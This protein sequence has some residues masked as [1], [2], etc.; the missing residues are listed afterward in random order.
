MIGKTNVDILPLKTRLN[1]YMPLALSYLI[2]SD[3]R[4]SFD[5][6]WMVYNDL[7]ENYIRK[8][9]FEQFIDTLTGLIYAGGAISRT[10]VIKDAI[11][12][13]KNIPEVNPYIGFRKS[14][15]LAF[16]PLFSRALSGDYYNGITA[17]EIIESFLSEHSER[18]SAVQ[19]IYA[20]Y[21]AAYIHFGGGNYPMA[22]KYIRKT[23]AYLSKELL[24]N[25]RLSLKILEI[26]V[27]YEQQKTELVESR[28]RSLQR[29]L[30]KEKNVKPYFKSLVRFFFRIASAVPESEAVLESYKSFLAELLELEHQEQIVLFIHFDMISW[31]QSR[32][33]KCTPG[34]KIQQNAARLF[35]QE[36]TG[37][38][39][40]I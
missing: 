20:Y 28:L 2:T 13:L 11:E 5:I 31:L 16:Y 15:G 30:Q 22:L 35:S 14:E 18:V 32:I 33:E 37:E 4:K 21:Y 25:I 3:Y 10:E 36:Y 27:F 8:E 39:M 6:Y 24:P 38:P 34:E 23:D 1:L 40:A 17:I 12:E 26:A 19:F 29:Q 9:L 7:K